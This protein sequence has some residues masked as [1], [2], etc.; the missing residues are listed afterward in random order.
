MIDRI[1][2]EVFGT[3]EPAD[4]IL[5]SDDEISVTFNEN[6]NCETITPETVNLE[7]IRTGDPIAV[8][9]TC[10]ENKMIINPDIQNMFIENEHLRITVSGVQDIYNNAIQE[11]VEW[12]FF[13]DRNPVRWALGNIDKVIFI[14]EPLV[15]TIPLLNTGSENRSFTITDYADWIIPSPLNGNIPQGGSETIFFEINEQL[16][17]GV[18]LDTL[19]ANTTMGNEPLIIRLRIL[20]YPPDWS[21]EPTNFQY[22]MNI[23]SQ[24]FI[25]EDLSTDPY[26]I[27]G[28]FVDNQCRGTANVVYLSSLDAYELFLTIYSNESIGEEISFRVWDA[29][30]C[31]EF[32]H[33]EEEYSFIAN[34]TFGE[35]T[36]PVTLTTTPDI[37][38]RMNFPSG[39]KWFS[40]NLY[41][42]D[43]S[44]NST[45]ESLSPSSSDIIKNQTEFDQ[46]VQ[47]AG[48]VG[49]LDS[50]NNRDMYLIKLTNIDILEVVGR[51]ADPLMNK[52]DI[53]SGWNWI[54]YIPQMSM[55]INQALAGLGS[56]TNDLIKSQFGYAQF[57]QDVGW[58]GSLSY[59]NPG[60]G[61]M[62]K[63]Q[64]VDTLI[65]PLL[66]EKNEMVAKSIDILEWPQNTPDWSVNPTDYEYN[67]TLTGTISI[68]G[69]E[70]DTAANILAAFVEDVNNPGSFGDCRG[71]AHP[72]YVAAFDRY[73]YFLM[74]YSNISEG[75]QI[76][77]RIFDASEDYTRE[78]TNTIEFQSNAVVGNA[79]E[80]YELIS[81]P[82]GIGDPG[83][84]P[85]TYS[86]S[87]N[88]PNPF[89]PTT[90]IGYGIPEETFIDLSIYNLLGQK[91]RVLLSDTQTAG[92][93][94][95]TWDGKDKSGNVVP[96]GM[97]FYVMTTEIF[98]DVK[99]LILLK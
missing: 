33:I 85:D 37:V 43:M 54:G 20:C 6:I 40:T 35:P 44:V 83:Y 90:T 10:N 76:S 3:P 78:L 5:Q 56:T 69:I 19:Y 96:T 36:N 75:E 29:S 22:T 59:L 63:S 82:L 71:I 41:S 30:A 99:K 21:V 7:Y 47:T 27:V 31:T 2:P 23:T 79:V 52:I 70:V 84:I 67:M 14:G 45:L 73:I 65:Y 50:I 81:K 17:H 48:W 80:P 62:L 72:L 64:T 38:Q 16:G 4:G 26:D 46:Y 57:V 11:P 93:R 24:L 92:Y 95:I 55:S 61:Y 87:Q 53:M 68:D 28:A 94:F 18:Y 13:V 34:A 74:I 86:L 66:E 88:F 97:Y 60:L 39:W 15:L 32:A 98:H 77:F 25:G 91:I 42:D 8:E 89:N 9:V 12:E 1:S 51:A 49:T 58:V